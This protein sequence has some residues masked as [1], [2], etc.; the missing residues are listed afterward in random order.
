MKEGG[1]GSRYSDSE[2]LKWGAAVLQGLFGDVDTLSVNVHLL[3]W[4]PGW[5][6]SLVPAELVVFQVRV[7]SFPAGRE[8][9]VGRTVERTSRRAGLGCASRGGVCCG[10][11]LGGSVESSSAQTT[12]VALGLP[13]QCTR[14]CLAEQEL[15]LQEGLGIRHGHLGDVNALLRSALGLLRPGVRGALWAPARRTRLPARCT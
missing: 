11:R 9:C 12:L 14:L 1:A 7:L 6:W 5:D 10:A 8:P 15:R 4:P 13:G 3:E 2:W